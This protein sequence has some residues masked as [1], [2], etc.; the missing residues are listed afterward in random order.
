L[1]AV[2]DEEYASIGTSD[3]LRH[4]KADAAIVTEPTDLALARAHRGFIVYKIMTE[5]RAAHG[6]R[7][8]EG[9]DAIMH[10]G[11]FLAELNQLEVQLRHRMPHPLV[12]PPS[13]HTGLIKGGTEVSVY[14]AECTLFIERRTLP[15]ETLESVTAE[16]HS[17][18][19]KLSNED[20]AFKATLEIQIARTPFEI[21]PDTQI[22]ITIEAALR[23]LLGTTPQH[24]GTSFWTD[25]ALLADEGIECVLLGPIGG[26]LHSAEEWVDIASLVDLARILAD[27]TIRYCNQN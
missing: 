15:G 21:S 10:M 27:T 7:Y 17:I 6:S 19:D 12:G 9:I 18:I 8:E 11:R 4:Y 20:H 1:T 25:A 13:L 26:G 22:V 24:K 16:L 2:A 3:I 5:G 23:T 14:A